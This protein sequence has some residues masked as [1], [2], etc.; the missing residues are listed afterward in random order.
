MSVCSKRERGK[1][2]GYADDVKNDIFSLGDT[3][4]TKNFALVS[5][6]HRGGA[7]AYIC[8]AR[9]SHSSAGMVVTGSDGLG[10][11]PKL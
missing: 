3:I 11:T 1:L 9:S 2:C 10:I 6:I 5:F 8:F 7:S 4:H